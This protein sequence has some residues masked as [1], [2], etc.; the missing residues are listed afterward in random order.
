[1]LGMNNIKKYRHNSFIYTIVT[2]IVSFIYELF[3]HGIFSSYLIFAFI[4]PFISLVFYEILYK[5]KDKNFCLI[6]S[7]LFNL[8]MLTFTILFIMLGVLEIYG[9]T[10]DLI[11][12]YLVLGLFLLVISI[13]LELIYLKRKE[14]IK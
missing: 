13:I 3:S 4:F 8:S 14:F 7:R 6:F 9:T 5:R 10:N 11:Y 12:V 1:M 2:M